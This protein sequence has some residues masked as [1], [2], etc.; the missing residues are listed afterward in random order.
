M[1]VEI[2]VP[3]PFGQLLR[4]KEA[5][6]YLHELPSGTTTLLTPEQFQEKKWW[7]YIKAQAILDAILSRQRG[8]EGISVGIS[9]PR[10]HQEFHEFSGNRVIISFK[11]PSFEERTRSNM[12]Q[13]H[14]RPG[15]QTSLDVQQIIGTPDFIEY[16][17]PDQTRTRLFYETR[18][19]NEQ[20]LKAQPENKP[21][22][23]GLLYDLEN[24]H[25][26]LSRE[27]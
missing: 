11:F 19:V 26:S 6:R 18:E 4:I 24:Q 7:Q 15:A 10:G 13:L 1:Q 14:V 21:Y 9:M 16:E 25:L 5:N 20:L 2:Y 3:E 23:Y 27:V 17:S 12:N 22:L 8:V